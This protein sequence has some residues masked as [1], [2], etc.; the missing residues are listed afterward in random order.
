MKTLTGI[1]ATGKQR[2]Q[3]AIS[4]G[5]FIE[6][7]LYYLTATKQWKMDLTYKD[8][9]LNGQRVYNGLNL[10]C[11]YESILP[12]GIAV[13]VTDGGEPFLINDFTSGRVR[14]SLLSPEEVARVKNF[15]I[16]QRN[17]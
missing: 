6:I 5:D 14:M 12:F 7:V 16:E 15:Y 9:Q 1:K 8:F 2:L 10:L 4:N 11:Q 3:T 13:Q 17:D